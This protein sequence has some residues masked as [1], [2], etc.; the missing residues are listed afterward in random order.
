MFVTKYRRDVIT[1]RV[2]EVLATTMA[3]VCDDFGCDLVAVETDHDHAHLLV[4]HPPKIAISTLVNSLK[5]VS[6]RRIR[7]YD[8]P[9]VQRALSGKHFWSR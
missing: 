6:A 5:G 3:E 4:A 8:Y 9:E 2:H 1:D 7:Q